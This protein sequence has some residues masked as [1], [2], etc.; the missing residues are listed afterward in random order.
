[1]WHQTFRLLKNRT[2]SL[3]SSWENHKRGDIDFIAL[4]GSNQLKFSTSLTFHLQIV[5]F[6]PLMGL[7]NDKMDQKTDY[8]T[9]L[10]GSD[11][12]VSHMEITDWFFFCNINKCSFAGSK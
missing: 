4:N 8:S 5:S 12:I 2:F 9:Y 7:D 6:L 3:R 10:L 1:M 11:G